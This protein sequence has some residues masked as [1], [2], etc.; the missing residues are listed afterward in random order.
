ERTLRSW[1]L[2][3]EEIQ[4]IRAEAAQL[5]QNALDGEK[6]PSG[7]STKP[8]SSKRVED[9]ADIKADKS[10]AETEI[11]APM[12]GV[13]LEKN[14]NIGDIVDPSQDLFKIAD[15]S[16]ME[17]LANI[18]EEDLPA[19]RALPLS[20]RRWKVD[21]KSDPFDKAIPGTFDVV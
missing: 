7:S 4:A 18:Y 14:F 6:K 17:V 13:I 20:Q 21:L 19:I 3:E 9:S 8:S 12:D 2:T 10:W 5:H 11:R 16:R 1:R 15:L